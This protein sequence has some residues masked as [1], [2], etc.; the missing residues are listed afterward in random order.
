[1][2]AD[3][4]SCFLFEKEGT[5]QEIVHL[6]KYRGIKSIGVELGRIIGGCMIL[7]SR[8]KLAD[9]LVPVPLHRIKQRERGYNQS[10]YLCKGISEVTHIPVHTSLLVRKK[11]TESQTQ[12][13]LDERRQNVGDAFI[14][15]EK[16]VSDIE[17]K[18]FILVDDVITTGATINAC[19]REL[20][21]CGAKAVFAISAALAQ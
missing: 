3:M 1:M 7:D 5:L 13:N 16:F 10:E 21:G 17:G 20:R 19:A 15:N 11:Y 14:V 18:V 6:L 4:L 8:Y 2:I 12:L 9:Y